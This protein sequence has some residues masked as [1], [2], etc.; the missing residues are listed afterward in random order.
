ME[1]GLRGIDLGHRLIVAAC[2]E[3]AK[4]ESTKKLT[5]WSSLSP[6]P[7]FRKWL[8][9]TLESDPELISNFIKSSEMEK[10]K[11]FVSDPD[12]ETLRSFKGVIKSNSIFQKLNFHINFFCQIL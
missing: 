6:V 2:G 10:F 4:D 7:L 1:K 3:M 5:E 8:Q 12:E 11:Q 9:N